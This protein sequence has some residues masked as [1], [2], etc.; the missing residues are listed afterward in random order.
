ME[1]EDVAI[2]LINKAIRDIIPARYDDSQINSLLKIF[3]VI[4]TKKKVDPS[5]QIPYSENRKRKIPK[6]E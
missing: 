2:K 4:I 3:D 6:V 5:W 1:Q